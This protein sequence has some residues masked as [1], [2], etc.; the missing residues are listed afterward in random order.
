MAVVHVE[1]GHVDHARVGRRDVLRSLDAD[2]LE[3][4]T[5][6]A[7]GAI[8]HAELRPVH[9]LVTASD[10]HFRRQFKRDFTA[11]GLL[12]L[13]AA[14]LGGVALTLFGD[15]D[16]PPPLAARLAAGAA[17]GLA[18]LALVGYVAASWLGLHRASV[19]LAAAVVALPAL[20][21]PRTRWGA[22]SPSVPKAALAVWLT[23]LG[24]LLALVFERAYYETPA[25]IFTGIEHNLGDLPF[26]LGIVASFTDAANIP[27][28]H[29]ELSGVRLTYPFLADFG[30]AQLVVAGMDVRAAMLAH[31]LALALS[32]LLLLHRFAQRVTGDGLA[33][34]LTPLFLFLSGGLGF[35]LL[36][37][38]S[39][40]GGLLALLARL[41]HDYTITTT[42]ELRFGNTLICLLTTQRSLLF[43]T[44]LVLL[45]LERLWSATEA[46]GPTR[47]HRLFAGAGV[48]ASL[49]PLVHAHAFAVMLAVAGALALL[50]PPRRDW[51]AF[52][53]PVLAL[54]LPQI[55]WLAAGSATQPK[56]FLAWQP[57]WD[58]GGRN[59][60]L[61][62]L[63]NAG[64]FL[65]LLLY[66]CLKTAPPAL[67]RFHAP[68]WALFIASNLL[69]LSPWI[70]DNIKLLFFWLLASA[71]IVALV[72]ARLLR[73]GGAK[74]AAGALLLLTLI[75]SGGIDL[76]RVVSR[77]IRIRVFDREEIQLAA[78]L[79]RATP[80]RALVLRAPTYDSPALLAGRRAVLGYLGHVWSQGFT[81]GD[82]ERDVKR[83]YAG[84]KDAEALLE[85]YAVDYILVGPQERV[86]LEVNDA[87]LARFPLVISSGQ[88]VLRRVSRP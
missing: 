35:L 23:A 10:R 24:V 84:A 6:G 64:L 80:P 18:L 55:A 42:G 21:V 48:V 31:N 67:R 38:E 8:R 81:A 26:H 47:R 61:F 15:E 65:P 45:A 2:V 37:R 27:P 17:L 66:G 40:G 53:A 28:E 52:F 44:P 49:L 41:P 14:A 88:Y 62:W 86:Q 1:H 87:F 29:P 33:A 82:R 54:A 46:S 60:L 5:G 16:D 69:R 20:L 58:S 77:Q 7:G 71:P 9:L 3:H 39:R 72:V 76:W 11:V 68:F 34:A 75:L 51:L 43:G 30:V 13:A 74:R 63:M 59:L 79:A 73:A 36:W 78:E 12:V 4:A 83:I 85:W 25:G 50:F 22:L 57:G 32:L 70:W 19:G 56:G